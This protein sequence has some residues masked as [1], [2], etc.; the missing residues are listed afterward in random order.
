MPAK[1]K[2]EIFL[3]NI[4]EKNK[5]KNAK[6]KSFINEGGNMGKLKVLVAESQT[7]VKQHLTKELEKDLEIAVVGATDN[8]KDAFEIFKRETLFR[9][10]YRENLRKFYR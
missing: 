8:G 7:V 3:T 6:R 10:I 4:V 9:K 5:T 1:W 2:T